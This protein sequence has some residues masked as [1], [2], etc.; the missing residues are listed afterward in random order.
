MEPDPSST[1]L[2]ST[3]LSTGLTSTGASPLGEDTKL[4]L[5]SLKI[6]KFLLPKEKFFF[7][8]L[9]TYGSFFFGSAV[10]GRGGVLAATV[11]A[12]LR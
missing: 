5:E 10:E 8:N 11:V 7:S 4:G 9:K 6:V 2:A 1:G 12:L 3:C